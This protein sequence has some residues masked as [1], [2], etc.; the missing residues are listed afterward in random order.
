MEISSGYYLLIEETQLLLQL[1]AGFSLASQ[2]LCILVSAI[3][4][5]AL[6]TFCHKLSFSRNS[7][8]FQQQECNSPMF[9][10]SR[11]Q[12]HLGVWRA[13]LFELRKTHNINKSKSYHLL[14]AYYVP[15]TL[16]RT[17]RVHP[18]LTLTPPS[19][20][21]PCCLRCLRRGESRPLAHGGGV[22]SERWGLG[23]ESELWTTALYALDTETGLEWPIT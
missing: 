11:L 17:L 12:L 22:A 15:N 16:L 2:L 23:S 5:Y 3:L 10:S 13:C 4:F 18:V 9:F 1:L 21:R 7:L 14:S 20:L 8:R 19:Q 6:N